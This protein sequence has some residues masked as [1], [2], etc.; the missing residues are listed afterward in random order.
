MKIQKSWGVTDPGTT[1]PEGLLFFEPTMQKGF[2]AWF[3]ALYTT[4]NPYTGLTLGEDPAVAIIEM[5]NED[6]LL[7][8]GFSQHQGRRPDHVAASVRRFPEEEVRLAGEGPAGLAEPR[9][10]VCP[11]RGTRACPA[12]CTPGT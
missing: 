1:C 5:Q 8:W 11:M 9:G 10:L 3:K 6:S 12:S 4:K 7:W 2:K